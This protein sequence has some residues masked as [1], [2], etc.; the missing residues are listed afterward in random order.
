MSLQIEDDHAQTERSDEELVAAIRRSDEGAFTVFYER[1][2]RRVYN[3]VYLRLRNHSDTEEAVQEAF[4]AVFRSIANFGGRS[5]VLSWVY[6]IAKN[7]VNHHIRRAVAHERR[8]E[9]AEPELIRNH[10][11]SAAGTPEEELTLR[12]CAESVRNE[13]EGLSKWQ[14]EI[15]DLRHLENLPIAEISARTSR[16]P[17]AVRS[18]LCRVKHR[19]VTAIE[20][21][22]EAGLDSSADRSLT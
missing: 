20:M 1:Y 5:S 22:H 9:R 15:F 4:T 8:L 16:S 13:F 14:S 21:G 3:F 12:R 19:I 17:D 6:G 11:R 18:S 10:H 2:H 7:T